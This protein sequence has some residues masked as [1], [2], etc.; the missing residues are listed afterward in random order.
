MLNSLIKHGVTVNTNLIHAVISYQEIQQCFDDISDEFIII[1]ITDPDVENILPD[2]KHMLK[3]QFWD[4]EETIGKYS[5]IT[6]EQGR[7]LRN[8]ILRSF[9]EFENPKFI[10]NCMAGQSRSAGVAKAIECLYYFGFGESA[11]YDYK[12]CFSSEIDMHYRYSPNLV[13]FDRIIDD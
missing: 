9:E 3:I 13:V 10:I 7:T 1:S 12:T 6:E 11:K 5:P 8:F 2:K 4:I